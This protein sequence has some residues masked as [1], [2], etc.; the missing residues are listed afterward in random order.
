MLC[1]YCLFVNMIFFLGL[2]K[3]GCLF[4]II[5]MYEILWTTYSGREIHMHNYE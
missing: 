1:Q 2:Y 4:T 5:R 3:Q